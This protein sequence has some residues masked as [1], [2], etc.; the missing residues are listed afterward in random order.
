[1][2]VFIQNLEDL[3]S[4]FKKESIKSFDPISILN[5]SQ[6]K[7]DE[8]N[9]QQQTT[10]PNNVNS[11]KQDLI[12]LTKSTLTSLKNHVSSNSQSSIS[13]NNANNS[14]NLVL[15]FLFISNKCNH[16]S[17]SG[18]NLSQ[19]ENFKRVFY[20]LTKLNK[21][22]N[23]F[24]GNLFL[25]SNNSNEQEFN[26][27]LNF[28]A[29]I[30][31]LSSFL[32]NNNTKSSINSNNNSNSG[33]NKLRPSTIILCSNLYENMSSFSSNMKKPY[34]AQTHLTMLFEH[35]SIKI[36]F[37]ALYD[38][39][40]YKKLNNKKVEY[41]DFVQ[42]ANRLSKQL[43]TGGGATLIVAL[44]NMESEESEQ[45][46]VSKC[47]DLDI[48]FSSRNNKKNS[49]SFIRNGNKWLVKASDLSSELFLIKLKLNETRKQL[50]DLAITK[51]FIE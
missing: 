35:Q 13:N 27:F 21:S 43:R 39:E 23:L 49:H 48:I 6:Q 31:D 29:S 9:E 41:V 4:S 38:E 32:S 45:R 5:S 36:G 30:N 51:Y 18:S 24:S 8:L 34:G 11:F 22:I 37:I 19:N 16:D 28:H 26:S 2:K 3:E 40:F 17:I 33:S 42:E 12:S 47:N 25:S 50:C 15:N 10:T 14:E 44:V 1:M 46:L 20:T 7:L